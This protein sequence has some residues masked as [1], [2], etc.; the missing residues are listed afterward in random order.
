MMK[1]NFAFLKRFIYFYFMSVYEC[2]HG[3][4]APYVCR[5]DGDLK[6]ASD[7]LELELQAV[8]SRHVGAGN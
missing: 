6:T 8:V 5:V 3:C 2:L 1:M 4:I 7:S